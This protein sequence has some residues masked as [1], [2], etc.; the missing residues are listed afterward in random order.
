MQ[1]FTNILFCYIV[2]HWVEITTILEEFSIGGQ[3]E[4]LIKLMWVVV[5]PGVSNTTID[6]QMIC[7]VMTNSLSRFHVAPITGL[8]NG[9]LGEYSQLFVVFNIVRIGKVM[10]GRKDVEKTDLISK[11]V[12]LGFQID[13]NYI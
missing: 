11:C 2:G 10:L 8:W 7:G 5:T 9:N 1:H 13:L 6:K 3:H 12:I 4:T